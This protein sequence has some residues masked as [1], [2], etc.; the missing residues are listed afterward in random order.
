MRTKMYLCIEKFFSLGIFIIII[1]NC[2]VSQ[3]VEKTPCSCVKED[4]EGY[5]LRSLT[6]QGLVYV[7]N[8]Q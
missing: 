6:Q 1:V 8:T 5:D 3:C 2:A 7:L 4:G